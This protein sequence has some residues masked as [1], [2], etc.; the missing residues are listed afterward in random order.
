MRA[1]NLRHIIDIQDTSMVSDGMGGWVETWATISNGANLRAAIWPLR[2]SER[3]EAMKVEV[4]ISHKIRIRY[5]SGITAEM[6][7][8]HGTR[9]FNIKSIIVPDE[10]NIMVDM[11]AEEIDGGS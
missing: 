3:I 11:M 1:G 10:R 9:Y 5:H 2:G 6:R 8:K 7:I 4:A